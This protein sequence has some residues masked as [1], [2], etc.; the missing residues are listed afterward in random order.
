MARIII[1][2]LSF[3]A[4]AQQSAE[5]LEK[6][7]KTDP[8]NVV[9]RVKLAEIRIHEKNYA[10]AVELLDAYTD[11]LSHAGFRALAFGYSNLKRYE[12]EVR[13]L[14]IIAKKDEENHEWHM[15]LAHAYLKQA[16]PLGDKDFD[17]KSRL[18]TSGIQQ[19]RMALKI[20][21]KYK[22]A[23]D[24]LLKTLIEQKAHNE[25]RELLMEGI[26]SFGPRAD[27]YRELCRIDSNDGFLVQ[28]VSNCTESIKISP[29]YPDH[30]V[31]LVQALYDQ[32]EEVKAEKHATTAARKFPNSEFVQWAAGT[33]FFRKKNFPVST[34]YF[35]AAVK[36]KPESGRAQFGLAQSLYEGGQHAEALEHFIKACKASHET[37]ETFLSSGARLKQRGNPELGAK[38]TAAANSCR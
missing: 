30:Y 23:Y 37:V 38:Y 33:M 32:K 6:K 9:A 31:F 16:A 18:L 8:D 26:E 2:L 13:V 3:S 12:D 7:I 34:R 29:N 28:A 35:K 22:P 14:N 15:L 25:A 27:L 4:F 17:K 24:L 1:F 20:S 11:Q 19:L 5:Q 36:A 10:K 21:P